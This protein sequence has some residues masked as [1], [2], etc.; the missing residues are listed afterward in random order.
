MEP[1]VYRHQ[2][3]ASARL[4]EQAGAAGGSRGQQGAAAHSMNIYPCRRT[5]TSH[6]NKAR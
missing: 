5:D 3:R 1:K 4:Q 2:R 6:V